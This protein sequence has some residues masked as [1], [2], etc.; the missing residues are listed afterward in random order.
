MA[1]LQGTYRRGGEQARCRG[2][3]RRDRNEDEDEDELQLHMSWKPISIIEC[4]VRLGMAHTTHLEEVLQQ[5]E[6]DVVE[7]YKRARARRDGLRNRVGGVR[8][9]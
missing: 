5:E 2:T 1:T 4:D 6:G 3:N 7:P 9:R 8:H